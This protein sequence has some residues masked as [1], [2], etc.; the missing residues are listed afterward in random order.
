MLSDWRRT[1][2]Y[3]PSTS[4]GMASRV[5]L[6]DPDTYPLLF[7]DQVIDLLDQLRHERAYIEGESL[8]GW[9]AMCAALRHPD[10]IEKI[11]LNTAAGVRFDPSSGISFD[12]AVGKILRER[13][14]AALENPDE[15]TVRKRLEWLMASPERVTDELVEIRMSLYRRLE[16]NAALKSVINAG[17]GIGREMCQ[18]LDEAQV[19]KIRQPSLVFWSE[20]NPGM[21]P[22]IGKASG[23]PP[24]SSLLLHERR[25]PLAAMG[26]PR[27]A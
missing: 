26:T 24:R 14:I 15:Q 5:V 18:W 3:W 11:V 21:G 6:L 19:S 25:S 8:G 20:K 23:A 4:F 22:E 7:V 9:V 16:E 12:P 10:R 13:S 2:E 1:S 27:G 17:L